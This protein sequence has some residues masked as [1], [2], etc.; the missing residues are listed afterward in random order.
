MNAIAGLAWPLIAGIVLWRLVPTIRDIAKQRGFTV[1]VAGAKLTV[2]ELSEKLTESTAELR[3]STAELKGRL[4]SGDLSKSRVTEESGVLPEERLLRRVL[5]V[6]DV[7][8]NNSYIAAQ[9]ESLGVEIRQVTSTD[10]GVAAI[11]DASTPFDAV[12]SDMGRDE[13]RGFNPD[14]GLDLIRRIRQLKG[15]GDNI[16][17]FIFG[18]R[19]A[20]E[21]RA[22]ILAAGGKDV[23]SSTTQLFTFLR[24]VGRFPQS[25][26]QEA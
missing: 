14:A 10:T 3:A 16:P 22:E 8:S 26:G 12:I 15:R 9:L 17:I 24:G 5:W 13:P 2:Q 4:E 18:T 6:D 25:P 19:R 7:P 23:T 21:R 1:E 20:V 11:Q